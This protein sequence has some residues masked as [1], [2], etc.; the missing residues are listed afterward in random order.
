[1]C[2]S[3]GSFFHR[4]S[5]SDIRLDED[6]QRTIRAS[7][8]YLT[9]YFFKHF[10]PSHH[11]IRKPSGRES[12]WICAVF[13]QLLGNIHLIRGPN[14]ISLNAVWRGVH[15]GSHWIA[16]CNVSS[17]KIVF[18]K[19]HPIHFQMK[20]RITWL[21]F[22]RAAANNGVIPCASFTGDRFPTDLISVKYSSGREALMSA[23]QTWTK[24]WIMGRSNW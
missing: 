22:M 4:A 13:H 16:R 5:N 9:V 23:I 21:C 18:H 10:C 8:S 1:M 6:R 20:N 15:R 14:I 19:R 17:T 12:G 11:P 2:R 24:C 7:R 3:N